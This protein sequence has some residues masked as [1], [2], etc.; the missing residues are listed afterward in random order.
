MNCINKKDNQANFYFEFE[1]KKYLVCSEKC[2]KQVIKK[3][4]RKKILSENIIDESFIKDIPKISEET[5]N[6]YEKNIRAEMPLKKEPKIIKK[7][8]KK[9]AKLIRFN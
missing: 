6:S 1:N 3:I 2:C 8:H 4:I 9:S 7:I 5:I